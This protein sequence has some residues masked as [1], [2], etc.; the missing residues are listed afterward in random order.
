MQVRAGHLSERQDSAAYNLQIDLWGQVDVML[1]N[2][3]LL[4]FVKLAF[5]EPQA[6]F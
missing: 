6:F 2:Q 4:G 3:Y 1:K 5:N